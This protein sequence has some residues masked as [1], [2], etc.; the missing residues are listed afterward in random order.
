MNRINQLNIIFNK[1][2]KFKI[3]VYLFLTLINP[4]I[5]LLELEVLLHLFYFSLI[6]LV[7]IFIH[8]LVILILII[9]E[10]LEAFYSKYFVF[11]NSSFSSKG[12]LFYFL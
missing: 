7:I 4:I 12:N 8:F 5:E 9:L 2:E 1:R 11:Y 10:Y 3:Y 6:V